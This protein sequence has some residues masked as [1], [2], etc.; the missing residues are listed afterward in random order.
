MVLPRLG[1]QANDE[2]MQGKHGRMALREVLVCM[3]WP[4]EAALGHRAGHFCMHFCIFVGR[5]KTLGYNSSRLATTENQQAQ[6][7][8]PTPTRCRNRPRRGRATSPRTPTCRQVAAAVPYAVPVG[9]CLAAHQCTHA[10]CR[11]RGGLAPMHA[12]VFV[13]YV[14]MELE[15][16]ASVSI[17]PT[18]HFC[19]DVRRQGISVLHRRATFGGLM[20]NSRCHGGRTAA[21]A[22]LLPEQ[23]MMAKCDDGRAPSH[24]R[25]WQVKEGAGSEER[26]GVYVSISEQ[27]ELTGSK[28]TG[29]QAGWL[30]G[31][32]VAHPPSHPP[33]A[34]HLRS[35]A[36]SPLAH[37]AC[38]LAC[39][40]PTSS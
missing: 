27:H 5:H 22:A 24:P 21:Q 8:P 36:A 14:K 3:G 1:F 19:L 13:L 23:M 15:N 12:Q 35:M 37:T 17:V 4:A 38:M 40:Q 10:S 33:T 39:P 11:R 6:P 20:F 7:L 32:V 30:A 9:M 31:W 16:V 28:G 34:S 29:R 18:T 2:L 26:N 25:L